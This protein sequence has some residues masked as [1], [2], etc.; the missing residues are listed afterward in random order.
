MIVVPC[1]FDAILDDWLASLGLT[2]PASAR[3]GAAALTL[4]QWEAQVQAAIALAPGP[5][6]GLEIGRHV[7]LQHAGPL[8]YLLVNTRTLGELLDT[9][10]LLERWFYGRQWAQLSRVDERVVIAW[11]QR[12]GRPD[13]VLEQLHAMALLSV[14]RS[15]CPGAGQPLHIDLMGAAEGEEQACREAFG[16]P[17]R[18]AQPALRLSFAAEALQAPIDLSAAML[19]PAWDSRQRTLRETLPNATELVR[20]V[21][22]AILQ[23][24]PT[25]ASID[26]VAARLHLSRRTLQ[27]RLDESGCAYRQL[28][29]AVR[30]CHAR[31]LLDDPTLSLKEVAFL[32]GYAEQSAFNHAYQR[33]YG[34]APR[35][36]L[37]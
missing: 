37:R 10:L 14:L 29:D 11:D 8:G 17:L 3:R 16:C 4:E 19:S 35:Q 1:A 20:A 24:L 32:L 12:F 34:I 33:W 7:R 28:L 31:H 13:R 22:E 18:F 9:Y 23:T 6:R 21:R 30:Q 26:A 2:R 27:R 5:A 15:V 25:G 36:P